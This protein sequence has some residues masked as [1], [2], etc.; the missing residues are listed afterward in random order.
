MDA[1]DATAPSSAVDRMMDRIRVILDRAPNL[2]DDSEELFEY[3][4]AQ[5]V[6]FSWDR[7]APLVA[8]TRHVGNYWR[9]WL[10]VILRAGPMRP[11]TICRLL[12]AMDPSHPLSQRMLTQNLRML[13]GDGLL[14]RTVVADVRK[15]V[16][17][18]LTPLGRS[19]SDLVMG[20]IEWAYTNTDRINKARSSF[21]ALGQGA[22]R[23][24]ATGQPQR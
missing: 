22:D 4:V 7:S 24:E 8:V 12:E 17:Y 1:E 10:L 9:N 18:S 5:L 6:E 15:H 16:E 14:T 13:E 20:V 21:E 2:S 3:L 23:T 19:L 11:S